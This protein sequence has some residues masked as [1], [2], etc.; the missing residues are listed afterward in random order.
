MRR[1]IPGITKSKD[2][3]VQWL[4]P[5]EASRGPPLHWVPRRIGWRGGLWITGG[6]GLWEREKSGH[7]VEHVIIRYRYLWLCRG[8][9]VAFSSPRPEPGISEKAENLGA[10]AVWGCPV[11]PRR[12]MT[13]TTQGWPN[14][15]G[16]ETRAT[17][18]SVRLLPR[19]SATSTQRCQR[20]QRRQRRQTPAGQFP[21]SC[22]LLHLVSCTSR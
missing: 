14:S 22:R 2:K 1:A 21:P 18:C 9:R 20:R 4:C 5:G 13:S 6:D 15:I 3:S 10:C 19:E 8:R 7:R 17:P 12:Q 11:V 16:A